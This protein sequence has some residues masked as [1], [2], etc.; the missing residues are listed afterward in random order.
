MASARAGNRNLLCRLLYITYEDLERM[1]G[2]E[3]EEAMLQSIA[4]EENP[5]GMEK[6]CPESCLTVVPCEIV[7]EKSMTWKN[8]ELQVREDEGGGE[9]TVEFQMPQ[10]VEG[11]FRLQG[12]MDYGHNRSFSI[13]FKSNDRNKETPVSST[14]YR[15]YVDKMG[16]L[17]NLGYKEKWEKENNYPELFMEPQ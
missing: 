5:S 14:D 7:E 1:N 9:I 2:L 13:N 17:F 16:Y 15:W 3:R 12:L 11:Y 4:L 8:G 10:K 6:K